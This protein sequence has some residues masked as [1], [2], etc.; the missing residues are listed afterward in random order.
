VQ[1]RE[2][3]DVGLRET[4]SEINRDDE[5]RHRVVPF[6]VVIPDIGEVVCTDILRVVPYRRITCLGLAGSQRIIIKFSFARHGARRH[7][8][9]SEQGCRAFIE[10]S[11]LAPAVLFSGELAGQGVYALVFEYLEDGVA[12]NRMLEDITSAQEREALLDELMATIALHHAGGLIQEDLHLGNFMVK[13][14][15]IYSIDGDHVKRRDLPVERMP[16]IRNLAYLLAN[17]P[18]VFGSGIDARIMTYALRRGWTFSDREVKQLKDELWRIRRRKLSKYLSRVYRIREPLGAHSRR[19][20]HVVYDRRLPDVSLPDIMEASRSALRKNQQRSPAGY[21][22]VSIRGKDMLIWSSPGFGPRMLRWFWPAGRVW[23]NALMLGRLGMETPQVVAL[24]AR[25]KGVLLWDCSVFFKPIEGR[26]LS[27][28]F[29]SGSVPGQDKERIAEG[30]ADALSVLRSMGIFFRPLSP[31]EI[32]VSK[33]HIVFL[34]LHALRHPLLGRRQKQSR[35]LLSFL[36]QWQDS[37][38]VMSLLEDRFRQRFL[39]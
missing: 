17:H 2:R 35:A 20:V 27:D 28:F 38:G 39:I 7:F 3:A 23:K 12:L 14:G 16:S 24:V 8:T 36:S 6:Q 29:T 10:K 5:G 21:S 4:L 9:R 37:P 18:T 31:D 22:S 32:L 33:G 1:A 11:I 13:Q 25:R 30:L 26:T 19:G 15:R 34:G